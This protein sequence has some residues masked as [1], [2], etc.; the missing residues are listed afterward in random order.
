MMFSS[1]Q[2]AITYFY[3]FKNL[4]TPAIDKITVL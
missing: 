4:P 3:S 2:N 1:K